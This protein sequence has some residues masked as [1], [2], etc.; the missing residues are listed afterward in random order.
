M[1]HLGVRDSFILPTWYHSAAPEQ[2]ELALSVGAMCLSSSSGIERRALELEWREKLEEE[3]SR[4]FSEKQELQEKAR[5]LSAKVHS[6]E[7]EHNQTLSNTTDIARGVAET[8]F[9]N[10]CDTLREVL[11]TNQGRM[12]EMLSHHKTM[13]AQERDERIRA[14]V[15]SNRVREQLHQ[16]ERRSMSSV[17]SQ[18]EKSFQSIIECAVGG[19]EH[20]NVTDTSRETGKCDRLL[21][22][23]NGFRCIVEVKDKIGLHSKDDMAKFERDI[24][25][26][27]SSGYCGAALFLSMRTETIPCRGRLDI[28]LVLD[29]PVV[30]L[31]SSDPSEILTVIL[32]L[33]A[34]SR[35]CDV[36][37]DGSGDEMTQTST[38]LLQTNMPPILLYLQNEVKAIEQDRVTIQKLQ[39]SLEQRR[40][41]VQPTLWKCDELFQ[42]FPYLK[43]PTKEKF[44]EAV[45]ALLHILVSEN[46]S[47]ISHKELSKSTKCLVRKTGEGYDTVLAEA[48]RRKTYQ[49][50]PKNPKTQKEKT[51]ATVE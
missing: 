48:K 5:M 43:D 37:G 22:D 10:E 21:D 2:V 31:A 13:L 14:Q 28:E 11:Q 26:C 29:R 19:P 40:K 20:W 24:D 16:Y 8:I 4:S 32:L 23:G 27:F 34:L 18:G 6:L 33:R 35:Q 12:D 46:A 9:K 44:E 15:E 45:Q 47:T 50:T 41:L 7:T 25:S 38:L 3:R 17:G 51:S 39:S 1:V 49:Q 42:A 30:W 36:S